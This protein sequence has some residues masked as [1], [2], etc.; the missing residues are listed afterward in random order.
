MRAI[1]DVPSPQAGPPFAEG[2]KRPGAHRARDKR[3][4]ATFAAMGRP[5]TFNSQ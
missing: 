1:K 3:Q 4:P 5:Y 2:D